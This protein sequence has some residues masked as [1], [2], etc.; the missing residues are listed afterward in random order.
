MNPDFSMPFRCS[1][2]FRLSCLRPALAAVCLAVTSALMAVDTITFSK[3]LSPTLRLVYQ[4]LSAPGVLPGITAVEIVTEG[5]KPTGKDG[6]SI[7]RTG[8]HLK[9]QSSTDIGALYGTYHLLRLDAAGTEIPAKIDET[10]AF[11]LRLLNHWDNLDGTIER[12]YAG[13]SLWLW[14]ELPD[15]ISPRYAEYARRNAMVGINAAVLNNV[16]ASPRILSSEYLHKVKAL[17]D[18]L[19]PYGIRVFL[20]VNFASPIALDSLPTADPLDNRVQHWWKN[21][22]RE[23]YDLIPDFGGF[24]VKA[25]S[26]GQPGPMDYG[27]THADGANM[28]ARALKPYGGEVMWRAFVYSPIDA[29]RAKQAYMEFVPLDGHFEPNVTIQIKNGP[30]DFQPREPYSPLFGAMSLTPQMAEFQITQEYLGHAN[31][32]AFLAPMWKEFFSQ[33]APTTL[34]AVAGVANV[35]DTPNMTGHPLADANWYA[36]GRLAWDPSLTSE[37]I[38]AEWIDSHLINVNNTPADVRRKLIDMFVSSRE[39][40]V[41][42]MM[43]LGL[44]HI[45]AF[46]H[47]YGPEPWCDVEGARADWLPR[48]YHQADKKGLGFDRT[49]AGSD[50]VSQYPEPLRSLYASLT[51]CP[52]ELLLWFHHVPWN[53]YISTGRTLW[54]ELCHRY[55]RGAASVAGYQQ[56]WAEAQPYI[57]A[58]IWA[59][60]NRRLITQARDAQWW[61]DACVLYFSQFSGLPPTPE[62]YPIHHTLEQLMQVELGIDNYTN[63]PASLLDS[64][65]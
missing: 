46:G 40:V 30:I 21:K 18:V 43:P 1:P 52:P 44:H 33:V 37:E 42:Y 39:T 3:E 57:D 36:F 62:T 13:R 12:G 65:R 9:L 4:E 27:R 17:A 35:G 50:A 48:Y 20:S 29:D 38:A 64:K 16:N 56:V 63:P 22:A 47:H 10:P 60:V 49:P 25:N 28:L 58:D 34:T 54:E 32:L 7:S 53:E 31:H 41:D 19:R 14:N 2:V 59:D 8:D 11:P 55:A 61:K 26:E 23:I 51:E 15:S 5:H 24:L 45:F 6:Y